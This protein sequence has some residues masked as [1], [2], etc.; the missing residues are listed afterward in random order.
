MSRIGKHPVPVPQGVEVRIEG[1][2][3]TAK[4]KLGEL[5]VHLVDEVTAELKDGEIWVRPRSDSKRAR[6]M[7]GT[8]RSL[9]ANAVR[10][11]H[12]GFTISLEIVGVGYRAAVQGNTL[13]LQV[14]Y[15]H[16]V[17]FPIPEGITIACPRPTLIEVSGRD[18]QKVGQVAANIRAIRPPEP[19]KGKGIRY[20]NELVRRKEGKKK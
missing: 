4:G 14:G 8:S 12:E 2:Q 3:V 18:R 17:V 20:Q 15:S 6:M 9:V 10:G 7:W 16:E 19:Y 5:Q 13:V 11:V 1:Q